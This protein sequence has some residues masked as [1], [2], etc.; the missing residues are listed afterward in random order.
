MGD[1][2]PG[3]MM[4]TL[5]GDNLKN[6]HLLDWELAKPGLPGVEIGQFCAEMHLLRRF[7]PS[8]KEAAGLI[9]ETFLEAYIQQSTPD[10]QVARDALVHL[11]CHLVILT[12]RVAWGDKA[13]TRKVVQEGLQLLIG[14]S[15]RDEVWLRDSIVGALVPR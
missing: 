12:P 6:I 14:A 8:A 1:F 7:H 5:D 4:V 11:A 10:I 2:W 9:L 13:S 15:S 3:N